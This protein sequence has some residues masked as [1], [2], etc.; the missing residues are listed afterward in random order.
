MTAMTLAVLNALE[1]VGDVYRVTLSKGLESPRLWRLRK[2]LL[3]LSATTRVILLRLRGVR[4][5][6]LVAES[7]WGLCRTLIH[8]LIGRVLGYRMVIHHHVFGYLNATSRLLALTVT[9]G[10]KR[11]RHLVLCESMRDAL[12]GL[13]GAEDVEVLPNVVEVREAFSRRRKA[14]ND[15]PIFGFLGNISVEKGIDVFCDWAFRLTAEGYEFQVLIAGPCTNR[16]SEGIV[17][18]VTSCLPE[19][20][21]YL[22]PVIGDEKWR[23]LDSIDV[24]VF[25]SSYAHEAD[26]LVVQEALLFGVP[27][28]ALR[29]GCIAERVRE[30]GW[31][32][33]TAND[34]GEGWRSLLEAPT[35]IGS[36][37]RIHDDSESRLRGWRGRVRDLILDS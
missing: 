33:E 28:L 19:R 3:L 6:Y 30:F 8:V 37:P 20:A 13:Y 26:P 12:V 25:P 4:R 16:E 31:V 1:D 2:T 35:I 10:G 5:M 24:L 34:L 21:H 18:R 36:V 7:G 29:R 14:P 27:V 23:F 17:A 15:P 22:G 9:V 11:L 32:V